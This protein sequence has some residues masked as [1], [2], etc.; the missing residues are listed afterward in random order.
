MKFIQAEK[1]FYRRCMAMN[2][3]TETV[4]QYQKVLKRLI[5][6]CVSEGIG[7]SATDID[8]NSITPTTIRLHLMKL[9]KKVSLGTVRIHYAALRAFFRFMKK[10]EIMYRD[11]MENVEKPKVPIKEIPAFT[12]DNINTLLSV[13]DKNTFL[14][15][16]NYTITCMM[17]ATGMRR[18]EVVRLMMQDIH[19]DIGI[20][21]VVG[22]GNKFRSVPLSDNL[23]RVLIKYIKVRQEYIKEKRLMKSPYFFISSHTGSKLTVNSLTNIF[24]EV[25]KNEGIKGVRVSPHTFRHTFAKLFLLNGGDVFTLQKILGHSDITTTKKYVS[26]NDN[27]IR[28]QNDKYNPFENENWR[29]Y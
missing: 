24:E 25:G 26:L 23:R 17:F 10:E 28:L 7:T 20:I 19:F 29:Y 27:D 9:R 8:M 18:A 21:K 12:K 6:T 13:F 4:K 1:E 2:L 11:I 5:E 16:R 3:S 15:Y 22:K 14:G